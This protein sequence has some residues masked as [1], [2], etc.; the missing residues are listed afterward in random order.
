[1]T[2]AIIPRTDIYWICAECAKEKGWVQPPGVF[3]AVHGYCGWQCKST[4]KRLLIPVVDFKRGKIEP[5]FD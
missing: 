1:M 3:T 4:D 2:F 5:I